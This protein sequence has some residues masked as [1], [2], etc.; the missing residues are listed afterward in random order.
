MFIRF[1]AADE[2]VRGMEELKEITRQSVEMAAELQ[3]SAEGLYK[4][5]DILNGVVGTFKLGNEVA[6]P[7]TVRED[8]RGAKAGVMNVSGRHSAHEQRVRSTDMVN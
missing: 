4:Q 2:V 3:G 1:L 5:S 8:R 6:A 7:Q